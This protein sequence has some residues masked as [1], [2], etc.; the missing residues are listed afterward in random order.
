MYGLDKEDRE[1]VKKYLRKYVRVKKE[2]E[3]VKKEAE[4]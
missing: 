4:G 3:E 2:I 1:V